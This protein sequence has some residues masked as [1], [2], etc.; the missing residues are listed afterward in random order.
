MKILVIGGSG[1][2]G[3]NILNKFIEKRLD[4]TLVA[5]YCEDITFPKFAQEKGINVI[6]VD[7]L[8]DV[9]TLPKDVD[10]GI[11]VAG[12]SDHSLAISNPGKDLELSVKTLLNFL[13]QFKGK[14]LFLS[15]G[16]VYYGL[17]GKVK[18]EMLN[19]PAFSYGISKLTAENYIRY[20][21]KIGKLSDFIIFRLFY[22]FGEY[23]KPQR[24]FSRVIRTV[25]SGSNSFTVHGTG[26]SFIDP[27]SA[28]TVADVFYRAILKGLGGEAIFN[29]SRGEGYTVSS[30]VK[31]ISQ[32]LGVDLSI[33]YD[34]KVDEFPVEFWGDNS[35]LK[36]ML[37]WEPPP[38]EDEI[39]KYANWIKRG[40]E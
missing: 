20:F 34:Y 26:S 4:A 29:L 23:E 13:E 18:E 31:K 14:L 36:S 33:V 5:T 39:L 30:L 37:H 11:F 24:L 8:R 28:S 19:Y 22:A 6:R 25:H 2:I 40:D 27:L 17:K 32:V 10:I 15:S 21:K 7:L 12:N 1:F 3:R 16:A 35:R 38:L 9:S